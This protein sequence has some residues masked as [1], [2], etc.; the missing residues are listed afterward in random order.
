MYFTAE[1]HYLSSVILWSRFPPKNLAAHIQAELMQINCS[2]ISG[3]MV[4]GTTEGNF[5]LFSSS[6]SSSFLIFLFLFSP[7]RPGA[8]HWASYE[9]TWITCSASAALSCGGA[10]RAFP[11]RSSVARNPSECLCRES[12][13]QLML[14][15]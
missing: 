7:P 12:T 8:S 14:L 5:S 10:E 15:L 6:F 11:T 4:R 13:K 9:I 3:L 1:C 2:D